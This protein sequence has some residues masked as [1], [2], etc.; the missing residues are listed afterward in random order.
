MGADKSKVYKFKCIKEAL[1]RNYVKGEGI[2]R[3]FT[4]GKTYLGIR[5][6]FSAE[7]SWERKALNGIVVVNDYKHQHFVSPKWGLEH[8]KCIGEVKR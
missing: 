4:K 7:T 1:I 6:S 8:F 3:V 2:S 5:Y